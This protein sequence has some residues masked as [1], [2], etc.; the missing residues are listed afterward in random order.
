[1]EKKQNLWT[2]DFIFISIINF[3]LMFV[4]YMLM[5]TIAPFAVE[6]Y[7]ASASM[8]GLVSGIFIIGT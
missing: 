2:K 3:F 1:M 8:A 5:V 4:M 6:E 7:G